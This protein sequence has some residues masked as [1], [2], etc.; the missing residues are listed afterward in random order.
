MAGYDDVVRKYTE[1]WIGMAV[2]SL[3][4]NLQNKCKKLF[5]T[6]IVTT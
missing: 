3:L 2:H 6:I 4:P 1:R 5:I